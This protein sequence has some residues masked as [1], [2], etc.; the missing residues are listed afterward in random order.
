MAILPKPTKRVT[1][2]LKFSYNGT[3]VGICNNTEDITYGGLTYTSTPRLEVKLPVMGGGVADEQALVTLEKQ[4]TGFFSTIISGEAIAPVTVT[5][6]EYIQHTDSLGTIEVYTAFIGYLGIITV[7]PSDKPGT[8]EIEI[9]SWKTL[10]GVQVGIP[11]EVTCPLIFGGR[12]CNSPRPTQVGGYADLQ[13][14][15]INSVIITVNS[16]GG[17]WRDYYFNKGYIEK[18]GIKLKIYEW[19]QGTTFV[20]SRR[21]PASWLNQVAT[22]RPGCDKKIETC[23][24][25]NNEENFGGY[26]YA[27]PAYHPIIELSEVIEPPE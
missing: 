23:R 12:G 7:D 16:L 20:L 9:N 19:V 6:Y 14:T 10:L 5:I 15:Q 2:L 21:P 25:F 17:T 4:S 1:G 22:F 3:D 13:I 8:I 26:G 18:D 27:I 24:L 11:A